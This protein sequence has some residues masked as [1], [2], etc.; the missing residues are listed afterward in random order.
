[1]KFEYLGNSVMQVGDQT[2]SKPGEIVESASVLPKHFFKLVEE[3]AK[4]NEIKI[5]RK[6]KNHVNN[7]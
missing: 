1:M 5:P 6:V 2:V 7:K 3:K 4:F